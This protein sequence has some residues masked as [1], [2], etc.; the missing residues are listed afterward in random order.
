MIMLIYCPELSPRLIYILKLILGDLL[1]IEYR[2]TSLFLE[3]KH[4]DGPKL[5]YSFDPADGL[6]FLQASGLLFE[7]QI[8]DQSI[9]TTVDNYWRDLPIFFR[10]N[11]ASLLPF[12]IFSASFYLV[13]RYEE[14]L[15]HERDDHD[16]FPADQS[17]AFRSDFLDKPIVNLWALE[18]AKEI[19]RLY[20]ED[21]DINPPAYKFLPTIDIDNAWAFKHKGLRSIFSLFKKAPM[22]DR[23]FRYQVLRGKQPD[24]F[25]QYQIL[26]STFKENDCEP[27]YFFLVG[28]LGENDRNISASN[29]ALKELI[30][31]TCKDFSIGI[32]PSYRSN[33]QRDELQKELNKLN[34]I[35][36]TDIKKS[37]Q[38]F[39][40]LTIPETFK[41]LISHGIEEDYTMGYPDQIGFRAG[42][43]NPYNFFDLETN[44]ET[45]LK[46]IPFQIMDVTLQQYLNL[47]PVE[48]I[49]QIEKMCKSIKSVGGVF[50]VLWHNESLSEWKQWKGW[51]PVFHQMIKMA[52]K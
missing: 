3:F 11:E 26:T 45:N 17:L 7:R 21:V 28:R 37:R 47:S 9:N 32:H 52:A 24:P 20:G 5:N 14:Y 36:Q 48:A 10:T 41:K 50:T 49:Q 42:I 12:D 40:K 39:L 2:T 1:G 18:L 13:S 6:P 31:T 51:S 4:H 33:F 15:P 46:V 44:S 38:H 8:L 35:S 43:A 34:R 23:N 30:R 29:R 27:V 25:D 19:K 16:R 22:E